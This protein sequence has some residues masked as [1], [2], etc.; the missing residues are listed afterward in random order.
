MYSKAE[1]M[2]RLRRRTVFIMLAVIGLL[3]A[4]PAAAIDAYVT[5]V[6]RKVDIAF[7]NRSDSELDGVLGEVNTDRNYYLIE[8]YTM[9]KIRRLVIEEEYEF[10]VKADGS[11]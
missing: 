3:C 6:Y 9:K 5:V 2:N 10:A 11:R 1:Q 7:I 4:I 8:N